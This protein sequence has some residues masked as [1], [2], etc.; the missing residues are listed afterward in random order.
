MNVHVIIPCVECRETQH[1]LASE[2]G[3]LKR[4][5]GRSIQEC[6]PEM[7]ASEREMFISGICGDCWDKMFGELL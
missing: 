7:S 1:I 6:F 2:D 4:Q 3:L 5:E